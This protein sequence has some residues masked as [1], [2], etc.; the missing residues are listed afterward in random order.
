M[1]DDSVFQMYPGALS[2]RGVTVFS[3]RK[4]S[5]INAAEHHR[6]SWQTHPTGDSCWPPQSIKPPRPFLLCRWVITCPS[7]QLYRA[8][9]VQGLFLASWLLLLSSSQVP[10]QHCECQDCRDHRL[11]FGTSP[12]SWVLWSAHYLSKLTSSAWSSS[13]QLSFIQ[14][15]MF[16][17]VKCL[18]YPLSMSI[19]SFPVPWH[20]SW[21]KGSSQGILLLL[22]SGEAS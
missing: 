8:C 4:A 17:E 20:K 1:E 16:N 7:T 6:G 3:F 15:S 10:Y 11:L 22:W 19:L 18:I 9:G 13:L 12:G 14:T 21:R 2:P 5:L